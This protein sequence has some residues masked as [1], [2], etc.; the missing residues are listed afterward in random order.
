MYLCIF[1]SLR[2]FP[3]ATEVDAYKNYS[4]YINLLIFILSFGKSTLFDIALIASFPSIG[5]SICILSFWNLSVINTMLK[6]KCKNVRYELLV[7][8]NA[9]NFFIFIQ[10]QIQ[11]FLM[12]NRKE[13]TQFSFYTVQHF[14]K[15]QGIFCQ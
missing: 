2:D 3:L 8:S 5:K 11:F 6:I 4:Y 12:V 14:L 15:F 7:L 10:I 1:S 9:R 13:R